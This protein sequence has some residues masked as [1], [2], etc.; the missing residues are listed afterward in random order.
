MNR[1][2]IVALIII[3]FGSS[4][5]YAEDIITLKSGESLR[6]I[7][8][9]VTPTT[10]MFKIFG[11]S[12]GPTCSIEK[13]KIYMIKYENGSK[14]IIGEEQ[15][16]QSQYRD[17]QPQYR[18]QQPQ[19]RDQQPQYRD[20]QPQYRDQQPQYRDQ[21]PQYRDQQPQYRDQ[22]PQYRDQWDQQPQYWNQ[23][24][25]E[26]VPPNPYYK[27][28]H[29]S[30]SWLFSFVVPGVG[31][32]Y[33]GDIGKGIGFMVTN[34]VGYSVM[35]AGAS[36]ITTEYNESGEVSESSSV[37]YIAGGAIVLGSWI[38]AQID[39]YK[40]AKKK[41]RANGYFSWNVGKGDTYLTL[42]PEIKLP[43]TPVNQ[44]MAYTPTCGMSLKLHF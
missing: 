29:P 13:A 37:M 4:T 34:I 14:E 26:N 35:V 31:Q 36:Q 27:P 16:V 2:F 38:W 39:A 5:L 6:V 24:Q 19:Y 11:D 43:P 42:Q 8:T 10:V 40:G 9:K 7:I 20:Q 15:S 33:N 3:L 12:Q 23:Q 44:S 28:K 32:F 22:Q 30:L 21:Q 17:Q 1:F 18:D 25:Y 41:N